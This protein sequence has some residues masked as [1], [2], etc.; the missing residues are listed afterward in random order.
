MS[1][2][3]RLDTGPRFS[4]AVVHRGVVYLAGQVPEEDALG[5]V[6]E[7]CRS[8]FAQ[9]SAHLERCGSNAS[10][11]LQMQIFLT[12]I[13]H[14]AEMNAAFEA[15]MPAGC[16]PARATVACTALADPRW[17]VEVVCTAATEA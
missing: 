3:Q 16:A 12:D 2:L 17:V 4:E 7:Q 9:I 10:R 13:R 11:I 15:W 5:S 6:R 8:V 1:D 14:I